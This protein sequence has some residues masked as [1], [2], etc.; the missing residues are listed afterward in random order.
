MLARLT[1]ELGRVCLHSR[2]KTKKDNNM[3]MAEDTK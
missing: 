2:G 3:N 1:L